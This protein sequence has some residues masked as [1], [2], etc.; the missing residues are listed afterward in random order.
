MGKAYDKGLFLP[1]DRY[2]FDE[3]GFRIGSLRGHL[4]ITF[5]DQKAAYLADSENCKSVTVI[6]T[7][8]AD[9]RVLDPVIIMQD[10]II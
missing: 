7:T 3:S 1:R 5:S 10:M 8:S 2:N 6:D 4:I 9:R